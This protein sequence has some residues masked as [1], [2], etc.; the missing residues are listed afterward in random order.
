MKFII[1]SLSMTDEALELEKRLNCKCYIPGRDTDQKQ[2]GDGI[3]RDNFKAMRDCDNA[4][5]VI[6]DGESFGCLFDMGLAYSLGKSIWPY[7]LKNCNDK[8]WSQ[9]F[10]DK[11]YE[12]DRICYG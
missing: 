7:K 10:R 4:V 11:L 3:L 9:Y 5:Y 1:H 12:G 2:N 8:H 6:W